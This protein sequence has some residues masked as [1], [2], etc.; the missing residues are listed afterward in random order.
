MHH[1]IVASYAGVAPNVWAWLL[2]IVSA[3]KSDR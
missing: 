2:G 1:G 3:G